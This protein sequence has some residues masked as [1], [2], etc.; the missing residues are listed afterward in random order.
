MAAQPWDRKGQLEALASRLF[1]LSMRGVAC[2]MIAAHAIAVAQTPPGDSSLNEMVITV[3][4]KVLMFTIDL[5]VTVF[6]PD[7]PGPF[8]LVVVNHGKQEGDP[9]F[10]PRYRPVSAARFFLARGYAVIAPMRSGFSRSGGQY[11]GGGCNI[12]SNGRSQAED[13]QSVLRW[14]TEQAWADTSRVLILGQ[15]HGGWTSLAMGSLNHPG[16]MG[17]IN[18]AGG[19]RQTGCADWEGGLARAAA[20]YGGQTRVPSLWFYGDNDSYFSPSTWRAMHDRYSAGNPRT[21]LIAFGR[22]G[23]DAHG[24]FGSRAG[25]AIWQ[26]PTTRFMAALGLPTEVVQPRFSALNEAQRR[27]LPPESG[28]ALIDDL[29]AVPCQS[30]RC[31]EG[32]RSFLERAAPRAFASNGRAWGWAS[33]GVNPEER[34]LQTCS[35]NASGPPCGLYAVDDRVV[36][37]PKD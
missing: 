35:K 29:A 36:W 22:F 21:E 16:V 11:I 10:Q 2:L 12:E 34:A 24:M 37:T 15:S 28:H 19:L 9:K 26:G 33:G 27:N 17:V 32:Y 4:K 31:R 23:K 25:E 1:A 5:E 8:P 14:A 3:P 18:F 20:A 7:G 30:D 13:V 6:R